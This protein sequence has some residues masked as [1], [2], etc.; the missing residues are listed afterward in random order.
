[1]AQS[2]PRGA[3]R[4]A[5]A[6]SGSRA[7]VCAL[8]RK[9][10]LGHGP[11]VVVF[12]LRATRATAWVIERDDLSNLAG[13]RRDTR[14]DVLRARLPGRLLR[15]V[16]KVVWSRAPATHPSVRCHPVLGAVFEAPDRGVG[17]GLLCED[18]SRRRAGAV[19]ADVRGAVLVRAHGGG[20]VGA[21]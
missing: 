13:W 5:A 7:A 18:M 17:A 20:R 14:A 6:A 11:S 4:G 15:A 16:V 10:V 8:D 12:L 3:R 21:D 19:P 2:V 9:A 1:M